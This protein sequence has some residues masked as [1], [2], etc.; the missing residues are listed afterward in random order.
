MYLYQS[1]DAERVKKG[2]QI[3]SPF[4]CTLWWIYGESNPGHNRIRIVTQPC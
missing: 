3:G 2:L 4:F 1:R